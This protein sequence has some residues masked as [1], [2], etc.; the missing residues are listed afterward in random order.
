MKEKFMYLIGRLHNT[1]LANAL[2]RTENEEDLRA[3]WSFFLDTNRLL[4]SEVKDWKE[5]FLE[6]K[7]DYCRGYFLNL[8]AQTPSY[9]LGW[10]FFYKKK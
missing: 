8:R 1:G 3:L 10:V 4:L 6:K 7:E 5:E 9:L 2:C